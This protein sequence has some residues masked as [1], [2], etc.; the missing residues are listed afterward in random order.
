M[1]PYPDIGREEAGEGGVNYRG[2]GVYLEDKLL[3]LDK[4]ADLS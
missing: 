1:S 3:H 2:R 4:G